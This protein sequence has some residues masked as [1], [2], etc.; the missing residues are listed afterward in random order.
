MVNIGNRTIREEVQYSAC[1]TTLLHIQGNR[2][3][4]G[5]GTHGMI[6]C[7]NHYKQVINGR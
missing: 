5:Q 7:Q 3:S 1:L 6:T 2:G 4:T